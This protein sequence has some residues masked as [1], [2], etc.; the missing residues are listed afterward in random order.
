MNKKIIQLVIGLFPCLAIGQN[1]GIGTA[2]PA[3]KLDVK[4]NDSYVAQFN[5]GAPM[6]IGIYENNLYRGYWGS[7]SGAAEDVDFGTGAGTTGKL[8]LTIKAVPKLTISN[9]GKVGIGT[10]NPSH[11]L[12]INGGDLFVQSSSGNIRLGYN[13]GN[14]WQMATTNGGA[15]LRWYT[16][17][18][19]GV[20]TSPRH[21]FSQ[22]GNVGLGGFTGVFSPLGTLD[23]KG[24]GTSSAT[25]TFLLRNSLGDTLLRMRDDGRL[26]VGYNSNSYG[27]TLNLGGSGVNFYVANEAAFGGA[28][29]PTD[30]SLV[31][32]SNSGANNYLVLQPSWGNTG[33]GTYT[34][35]AKFHVNGSMLI[36]N[37]SSRVAAGYSMSVDGKIM[38][39]ELKVQLSTAWPDYVFDDAYKLMPLTDLEATIKQ[40]KHLPNIP[41]S[42]QVG[43]ANGIELGEMNRKL[44]EKI[45][46][47]TLYIIQINKE[48]EQMEKRVSKLESGK[49]Y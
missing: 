3:A 45:E 48:K 17:T 44:L 12:H 24:N 10:I 11:L 31:L 43:A 15:D 19:G 49:K 8:H 38:C 32:W 41:S 14:E 25:N 33:I 4:T 35:N 18:D 37:N 39:E 9:E 5:G 2:T 21:Y 47:L 26:G 27:R 34:P 13:G 22:N 42:A 36:G 46:E 40:Q 20:T 1:V 23:V 30:T 6:Y 7:Y 16:T 29:F 28:I